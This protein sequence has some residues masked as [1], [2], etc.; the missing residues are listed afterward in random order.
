M[1]FTSSDPFLQ[2]D[3]LTLRNTR[4][5]NND[6]EALERVLSR[7]S[8]MRIQEVR[9]GK[10]G[11]AETF[12]ASHIRALHKHIFG[13]VFEWAGSFRSDSPMIEG[14]R[15]APIK[16]LRK[17]DSTVFFTNSD[18][19][20]TELTRL[21]RRLK[22]DNH[23]QGLSQEEFAKK[24]A[25]IFADLNTIHP[26][27]EGNGRV[28]REFM[29]QLAQQAGHSLD[30]SVVSHNRMYEVSEQASS[31]SLKPM[32]RLM[33]EISDPK[34]CEKLRKLTNFFD[35]NAYD[36]HERY[37]CTTE[38]DRQYRGKLAGVAGEDFFMHD[39][40]SIIVGNSSDLPQGAKSGHE[41]VFRSAA[42]KS[43]ANSDLKRDPQHKPTKA[44][45]PAIGDD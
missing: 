42:E 19:I 1:T 6:P 45:G 14:R 21:S 16:S 37:L 32:Q 23:L 33:G 43:V 18:K 7:R 40:K 10:S 31:G 35:A 11:I 36:W 9:S 8:A 24:S 4:G 25:K 17:S 12:D 20:E 28:Q 15:A 3:G 29:S 13:D 34:R 41:I 39:G 27:R 44:K 26:F 38:P 30:F 2:S 5:I 22:K